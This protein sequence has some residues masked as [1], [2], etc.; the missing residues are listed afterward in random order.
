MQ[1]GEV[2]CVSAVGPKEGGCLSPMP[3]A[4]GSPEGGAG[5]PTETPGQLKAEPRV[6]GADWCGA[7][8][9]GLRSGSVICEL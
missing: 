9:L 1:L 3:P 7:T 8:V 4:A 6:K 5:T 2:W